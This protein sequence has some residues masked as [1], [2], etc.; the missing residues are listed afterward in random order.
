MSTSTVYELIGYAGSILVVVSLAMSSVIRLR[1][2]NL[3][4][5]G[6]FTVY[7]ALIGSIPVLVT[8][9]VIAGLDVYY[10]RKELTTRDQ[11]GVVPVEPHDRFL[12]AFVDHYSDDLASFGSVD[13]EAADVRL[14]LLRDTTLAGVFLGQRDGDDRLSVMVDYVAPPFR[15][16]R[17]G[18]SLYRD[19]GSRFRDLG[20]RSLVVQRPDDRQR[21]YFVAMGFDTRDGSLVKHVG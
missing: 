7:G 3:I 10:L 1:V 12:A 18:E 13:P 4:G 16:L 5:A 21:D 14:V 2:V 20:Y 9:L 19:D 11:L 6:V 8:N 17:S 15:D